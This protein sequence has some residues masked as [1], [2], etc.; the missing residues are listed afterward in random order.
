MKKFFISLALG[1]LSPLVYILGAKHFLVDG[2]P[3]IKGIVAGCLAA[4]VYLA[5][6]Q[7]WVMRR[8][9]FAAVLGLLAPFVFIIAAEPFEVIGKTSVKEVVAGSLAVALYL[10]IC[11]FCVARKGS[12]GLGA[13]TAMTVPLFIELAFIDR[14]AVLTQGVPL[15]TSGFLGSLV[16]AVLAARAKPRT[17]ANGV[18]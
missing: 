3:S 5:I 7:F 14:N 17:D 13:L 6:C 10:A 18:S 9:L 4:V 12:R 8:I 2:R 1:L 11:Q 16:G 15:L